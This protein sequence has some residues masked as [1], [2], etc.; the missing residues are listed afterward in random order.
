LRPLLL[1]VV[2]EALETEHLIDS[3]LGIE[4]YEAVQLP[5]P[6]CTKIEIRRTALFW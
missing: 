5:P 3:A 6:P 4:K 2:V 1:V